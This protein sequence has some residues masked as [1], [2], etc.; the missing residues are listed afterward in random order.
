LATD[1]A[2]TPHG[3]EFG[4]RAAAPTLAAAGIGLIVGDVAT[5]LAI[6]RPDYATG[7]GLGFSLES[8]RD[9][10]ACAKEGVVVRDATAFRRIASADIFLFDDLAVLEQSGVKTAGVLSQGGTDEAEILRLAATAFRGLADDRAKAMES[11]CELNGIALS[12]ARLS[13]RGSG[14]TFCDGARSIC[15]RD[16]RGLDSPSAGALPLEV[17][18]DGR[19]AGTVRFGPSPGSA[20]QAIQEL[21]SH[22]AVAVGL[23]SHRPAAELE[24]LASSLGVDLHLGSLTS[25]AKVDLLR[26]LG[27]RGCKVAYVGDC[28]AEPRVAR[29]AHVGI[30]LAGDPD[31]ERDRA[32]VR[33]LRADMGWLGPL[34]AL[35]CAHVDRIRTVH[36]AILLPNL[37]CIA[38][39]FLLRFTS[40][41]V[42]V[43]SN[44]GT[45][46]VYSG[47]ARRQGRAR[48]PRQ[49]KSA[50][51]KQGNSVRTEADFVR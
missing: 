2:V 3:E 28:A 10:A 41:P 19:A 21:R 24:G 38:G 9:V 12:T 29:E 33:V 49:P 36:G 27:R 46:A 39:A 4:R 32:Q 42:V 35:S 26:C 18:V 13:Y 8:L 5:A 37:A 22:G 44:L 47:L 17:I 31:P 6:L 16:A 15:V 51:T 23:L 34:R 48:N 45:L 14:I 7:P 43:L 40:L 1:L 20:A 50:A 11:A 30:S 25:D